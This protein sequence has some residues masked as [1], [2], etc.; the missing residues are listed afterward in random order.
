[1]G[2]GPTRAGAE[3]RY[4]PRLWLGLLT[5]AVCAVCVVQ[6]IKRTCT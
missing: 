2:A 1:M 3:I 6:T 4:I 5:C